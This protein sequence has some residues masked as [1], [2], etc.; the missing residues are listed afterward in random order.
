MVLKI[1]A[2]KNKKYIFGYF[3]VDLENDDCYIELNEG[4]DNYPVFFDIFINKKKYIIESYWTRKWIEERVIPAERQ[5]INDILKDNGFKYYNEI[6]MIIASK[7]HSSMD[8]NYLKEIKYN[9]ISDFVKERRKHLIKDFIYLKEKNKIIVFFEDGISKMIDLKT[10]NNKPFINSFGS[11]LISTSYEFYS[12]DDIYK[13]GEETP[14]LY[15]DLLNYIGDNILSTNAIKKEYDY[16]RQYVN[17]LKQEKKIYE[18]HDN[19]FIYNDIKTYKN[20]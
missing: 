5:N 1:F 8:D 4:L 18:L 9:E 6:L 12:Y 3:F 16:S 17:K 2:I 13:N 15:D 20:K 7:A 14:L 11:E 10:K 19:L